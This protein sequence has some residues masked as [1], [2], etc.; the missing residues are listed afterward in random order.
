MKKFKTGFMQKSNKG[1]YFIKV[2]KIGTEKVAIKLTPEIKIEKPSA[3]IIDKE[4]KK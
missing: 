3:P 4:T 1:T 2:I